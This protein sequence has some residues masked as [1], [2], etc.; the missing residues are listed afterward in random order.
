MRLLRLT[1][2]NFQKHETLDISFSRVT[3]ILGSSD[4]GKSAIL[5]ALRWLCLNDMGGEDFITH[6]KKKTEVEIAIQHEQSKPVHHIKRIRTRGGNTN[7]Y[8]MGGETFK[9]FGTNVP[10]TVAEALNISDINFQG[11]HDPPFWFALPPGEISRRLNAVIDLSIIDNSLFNVAQQVRSASERKTVSEERSKA[12]K[13]KWDELKGQKDRISEFQ[14]IK[15]Q[16]EHITKLNQDR[17][18]LE[19]LLVSI[20]TSRRSE[21][22]WKALYQVSSTAL[23]CK[24]GYAGAQRRFKRLSSILAQIEEE[25]AN[26]EA[27]PPWKPVEE[28]HTTYSTFKSQLNDLIDLVEEIQEKEI[29][30]A[31]LEK[32][33]H[34]NLVNLREKSQGQTCPLCNQPL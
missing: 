18:K 11:Q 27:P 30:I 13:L 9:S 31:R 5:R 4:E 23:E 19:R 22:K 2:S 16:H 14:D 29:E 17:D 3:S 32:I 24:M 28:A 10:D 21:E 8:E 7:T 6:G 25:T 20:D 33:H 1:L 34:Q 12:S 15:E 26:A